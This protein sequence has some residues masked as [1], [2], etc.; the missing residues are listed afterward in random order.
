MDCQNLF[1]ILENVSFNKATTYGVVFQT[2]TLGL[3]EK[4]KLPLPYSA[5]DKEPTLI[6]IWGGASMYNN[7]IAGLQL[8]RHHY[9]I[10]ASVGTIVI[11]LTKLSGLTVIM[12][13]SPQ[14]AEYLKSLSA[15]Y[16]FPYNDPNTLA[17]IK[18]LT[19][20]KLY[21]GY[22]TISEKGTTQLIINAF[23]SDSDIP[24]GKKKEL[25]NL[26][27][28]PLGALDE[29]AASVTRFKILAYTMFGVEVIVYGVHLVVSWSDYTFSIR[30]YEMLERLLE[31][32]KIQHQKVKVMGG[33][34]Y[35]SKD[36]CT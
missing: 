17:E 27:Y 28:I 21:L 8:L 35:V 31:E 29:K 10:I 2:A 36:S 12:T 26:L 11:Q 9:I 16:V 5:A 18:K 6:L 7:D 1:W 32:K 13:A 25:I 15:D 22:N 34:E 14:N 24:E 19:N 4:L 23:G 30:S 20:G 3:Y 33:L